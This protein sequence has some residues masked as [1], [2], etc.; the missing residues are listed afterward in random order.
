MIM[1][2]VLQKDYLYAMKAFHTHNAEI[3][4]DIELQY[5]KR[6][7]EC[8]ALREIAKDIPAVEVIYNLKSICSTTKNIARTL[9][10]HDASDE[11]QAL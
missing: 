11:T 4:Y 9:T 10:V 3:A 8:K 1:L 2:E 6:M 5:K 7:E